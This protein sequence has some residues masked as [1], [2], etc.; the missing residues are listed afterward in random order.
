[1]V[2]EN[3]NEA[4]DK[5]KVYAEKLGLSE[6]VVNTGYNLLNIFQKKKREFNPTKIA[7]GTIY[8]SAL[9]VGERKTQ[10]DIG[11]VAGIKADT[12]GKGYRELKGNVNVDILL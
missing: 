1:M 12:V 2:G 10:G 3:L 5:L 9:L 8:F 7:A 4:R 6:N 11:C